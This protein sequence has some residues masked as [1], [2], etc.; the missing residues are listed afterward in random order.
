MS[1]RQ[2]S[3]THG[4]P[5]NTRPREFRESAVIKTAG[6]ENQTTVLKRGI[7][8]DFPGT[9]R[10]A[11]ELTLVLGFVCCRSMSQY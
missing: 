1:L 10:K 11:E 6:E 9:Q 5:N 2:G 3:D 7:C 8:N 4:S